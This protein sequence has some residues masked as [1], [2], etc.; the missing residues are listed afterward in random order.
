[1]YILNTLNIM[2]A[3]LVNFKDIQTLIKENSGLTN[4]ANK[5]FEYVK[6][7]YMD[8]HD[9]NNINTNTEFE[10]IADE[11]LDCLKP[12]YKND[13]KK[14]LLINNKTAVGDKTPANRHVSFSDSNSIS[15]ETY[16][17][18][19]PFIIELITKLFLNTLV[20]NPNPQVRYNVNVIRPLR[21]DLIG[22]Q[23]TEY[24]DTR[25]TALPG[26]VTIGRRTIS[27][28]KPIFL[29]PFGIVGRKDK[30][31]KNIVLDA[32]LIETLSGFCEIRKADTKAK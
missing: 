29:Q 1:L 27:L 14:Y 11:R 17:T 22:D 23:I 18:K 3:I 19:N 4:T 26:G 16:Y 30:I 2:A 25:R 6:N 24:N 20:D 15:I 31:I 7:E 12:F 8:E 13:R 5:I 21:Q 10:F 9:I 32:T 28:K